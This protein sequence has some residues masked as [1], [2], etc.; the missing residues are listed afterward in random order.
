MIWSTNRFYLKN[1]LRYTTLVRENRSSFIFK[2]MRQLFY[3]EIEAKLTKISG[4]KID[5]KLILTIPKDAK[6]IYTSKSG[7]EYYV[8]NDSLYRKSNH[9]GYIGYN[10]CWNLFKPNGRKQIGVPKNRAKGLGLTYICKKEYIG[11]CTLND[12]KYIAPKA[13]KRYILNDKGFKIINPEFKEY[14]KTYKS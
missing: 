12:I 8:I 4:T 9:W 2:I 1:F 10:N 5:W 3:K 14:S 6:L 13:P 11:V 7:S